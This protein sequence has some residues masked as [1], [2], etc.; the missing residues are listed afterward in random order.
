MAEYPTLGVFYH[1]KLHFAMREAF[2]HH[3]IISQKGSS[4]K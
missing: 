3:G 2:H 4:N 1:Q